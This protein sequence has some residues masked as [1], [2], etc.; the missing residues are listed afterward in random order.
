M[1]IVIKDLTHSFRSLFAVGMMLV[2]PLLVT[3]L[4]AAAFGGLRGGQADLKVTRVAVANLDEPPASSAGL[5]AGKL[6]V[7]ALHDKSLAELLEATNFA[8]ETGARAAVDRR[9]ADVAVIIPAGFTAAIAGATGRAEV[10]L[11]HDPTLTLAP[12]II[13]SVIGEILDGFIG[14][15]VFVK[16]ATDLFAE[17]HLQ[18]DGSV[19]AAQA[20]QYSEWG[21][22]SSH[23]HVELGNPASPWRCAPRRDRR[24]R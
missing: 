24:G 14:G 6:I 17:N 9:E 8:S 22:G 11:Y 15:K 2:V 5:N 20:Q 1:D 16:T 23:H 12:E 3:G 19:I 10:L 7:D 18:L 4:F 21:R 13:K